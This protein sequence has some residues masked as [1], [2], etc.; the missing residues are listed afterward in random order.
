M[1]FKSTSILFIVFVILGA[2]VYFAEYRGKDER[3]KQEEA[4]KKAFQVEEKD[5]TDITLKYPD[6][7]IEGVKKDEKQWQFVN[8]AGIESDS[9]EWQML[10]SN[11]PK[12]ERE[13]TVAQNAQDLS[14]FGLNEPQITVTAKT[15][16]G[17]TLEIAFGAENPRKTYHYA[18]LAGSNDVFLAPNSW[19]TMFNK[20]VSDLRNKKVLDFETDD[21]DSVKITSGSNQLDLT[22]SGDHWQIKKPLDAAADDSEVTSFLSSMKFARASSFP[23]G[24]DAKKV[25]L[26]PP[27]IRISLHDKKA[28]A[29]RVLLI[30]TTSET[31]KYYARDGSRDAILIIEKEIPD[32]VRRPVFEWRDKS[33]TRIDRNA[34]EEIDIVR[35]TEKSSIN[36]A[37]ADW[38]LPDGRKLQFEK[39]STLL[40]TIE[41]DRVKDVIDPPKALSTYGL[42]K[43]RVEV[44]FHKGS[45]EIGRLTFGA[46]SKTPEG[47]Y[48]KTSDSPAVKVVGKDVFDKFNVKA[49]DLVEAPAPAA[50]PAPEKK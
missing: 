36:K 34:I 13:D 18:K 26:E 7:T 8:P 33:I 14:P 19:A 2:Y 17:Q 10:A 12:I 48:L 32:K 44:V 27:A 15:A 30:G 38:K 47:V 40:T 45:N 50:A 42:D 4:K 39:I 43:P 41:F 29:D 20:T 37:D 16:K 11:I 1:R 49:E 24:I 23:N 9:D 35:G 3:Q 22:K 6:R 31:D 28:N 25:G 21:I 46:E 5:I